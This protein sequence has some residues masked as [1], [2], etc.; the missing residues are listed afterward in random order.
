MFTE[1]LKRKK[2]VPSG[3]AR[4]AYVGA[5]HVVEV[6]LEEGKRFGTGGLPGTSAAHAA[7][8]E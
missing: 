5:C 6:V 2:S 3:Q 7:C 8:I 1:E 4:V